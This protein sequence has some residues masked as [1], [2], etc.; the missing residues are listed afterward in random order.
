[1]LHQRFF[2][3][4]FVYGYATVFVA[5]EDS[6]MQTIFKLYIQLVLFGLSLYNMQHWRHINTLLFVGHAD[7]EN[8]NL[9]AW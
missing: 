3:H 9:L 8:N 5:A 7:N 2:L 1:M 6:G 4:A